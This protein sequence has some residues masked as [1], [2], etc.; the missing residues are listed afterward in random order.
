M[1]P[2]APAPS[3]QL[4]AAENLKRVRRPAGPLEDWYAEP[5]LERMTWALEIKTV[6]HP[7]GI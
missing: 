1:S 3:L 2:T 6:W 4:A 5:G 7:V